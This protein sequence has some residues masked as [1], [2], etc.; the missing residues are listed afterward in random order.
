MS[1]ATALYCQV[2]E[3]TPAQAKDLTALKT[4]ANEVFNLLYTNDYSAGDY[5]DWEY[6]YINGED[7]S[8]Y[9]WEAYDYDEEDIFIEDTVKEIYDYLHY[10]GDDQD[11]FTEWSY[12]ANEYNLSVTAHNSKRSLKMIFNDDDAMLLS[13]VTITNTSTE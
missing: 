11:A 6:L 7:Y 10:D 12:Q 2:D 13:S 4:R 1:L 5:I 9:Y 8:Y 3:T